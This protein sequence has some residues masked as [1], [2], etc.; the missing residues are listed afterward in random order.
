MK[1][2][3]WKTQMPKHKNDGNC[4]K[5]KSLFDRYDGFHQGLRSWFEDLQ[6]HVPDAHI[7]C[8]GRGKDDQTILFNRKATRAIYGRSSHNYNAAIDIF[9]NEPGRLYEEQWFKKNVGNFLEDWIEWYGKP[10]SKF[11]ELPH[12]EVKDWR[13]LAQSGNI[14][15]V[16]P[17]DD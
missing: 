17:D 2:K 8:A 15:L 3:T 11:Y 7:S 9:R 5:C 1:N 14:K 4:E 13:Q 16:E 6:R 10:G 12:V